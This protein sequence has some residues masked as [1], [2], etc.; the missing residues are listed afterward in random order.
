MNGVV[1]HGCDIFASNNLHNRHLLS[2]GQISCTTSGV[3]PEKTTVN[4]VFSS[5]VLLRVPGLHVRFEGDRL[6]SL[7]HCQSS[8]ALELRNVTDET[9]KNHGFL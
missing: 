4:T 1:S 9:V 6:T 7:N 2:P 5:R 8:Q 3:L